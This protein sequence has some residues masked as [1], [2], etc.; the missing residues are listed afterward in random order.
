MNENTLNNTQQQE[1]TQQGAP[2]QPEGNGGAGKMFTQE[3][4]NRIVSERLARDRASRDAE[5]EAEM[6]RREAVLSC[7]EYI[8]EKNYDKALL[9]VFK[10][11]DPEEFKSSVEAL[12]KAFPGL[13]LSAGSMATKPFSTGMSHEGGMEIGLS[14]DEIA[15]AF[16]PKY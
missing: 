6:Q 15:S 3:D 14:D 12:H 13:D 9:D 8:T 1:N 5:Q 4:V 10:T 16:K 2:T 11:D 7:R